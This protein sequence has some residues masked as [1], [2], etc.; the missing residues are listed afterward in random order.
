MI[1]GNQKDLELARI[2]DPDGA[3]CGYCGKDNDLA[4]DC[5]WW[6]PVDVKEGETYEELKAR[7]MESKPCC[8]ACWI[9]GVGK[10]HQD[11]FGVGE[12]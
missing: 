7:G 6:Y 4:D 3:T 5:G 8:H 10:R 12:R 2:N 1:K 9:S 11:I